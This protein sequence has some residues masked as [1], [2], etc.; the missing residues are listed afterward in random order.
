[1]AYDEPFRLRVLKALTLALQQITPANGYQHDLS[2]SVFRGRELFGDDDPIPM[3]SILEAVDE[4]DQ[5]FSPR[6]GDGSAGVWPLLVQGFVED[7]M[8]NPTDPAHHLMAE[9]K[10]RLTEE[11]RKGATMRVGI[12]DMGGLVDSLNFGGGVVRPPDGISGKAYFWLRLDL[13]L[14]EDL[15]N[16]YE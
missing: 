16:P 6:G 7:D 5:D 15:S 11:R 4:Q 3:V 9:V 10:K 13:G 2:T 14:V 1:M 8:E 12:F